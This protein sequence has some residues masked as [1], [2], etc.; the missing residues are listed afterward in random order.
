MRA[1]VRRA[2]G[3]AA[4]W[5]QRDGAGAGAGAVAPTAVQAVVERGVAVQRATGQRLVVP[6]T[7]SAGT[8]RRVAE[9]AAWE[10]LD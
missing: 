2:G 1:S 10:V 7:N 5:R 9:Q 3:R 6:M 4:Q 8:E